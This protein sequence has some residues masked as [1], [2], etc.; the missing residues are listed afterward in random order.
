MDEDHF[1]KFVKGHPTLKNG[2]ARIDFELNKKSENGTVIL[3]GNVMRADVKGQ[4]NVT[5]D[6]LIGSKNVTFTTGNS[7]AS[8]PRLKLVLVD[9]NGTLTVDQLVAGDDKAP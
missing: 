6:F 4:T 1:V 2:T 8:T 9:E 5:G 7:K 3:N